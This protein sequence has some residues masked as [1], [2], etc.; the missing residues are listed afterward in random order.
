MFT[1]SS[2]CVWKVSAPTESPWPF[3]RILMP[4]C[5]SPISETE[6]CDMKLVYLKKGTS[7]SHLDMCFQTPLFKTT[8]YSLYRAMFATAHHTL[9][10]TVTAHSRSLSIS[11]SLLHSLSRRLLHSFEHSSFFT[12]IWTLIFLY[13]HFLT[14][15][16]SPPSVFSLNRSATQ[17][18]SLSL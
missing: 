12:L 15:F 11:D 8:Y 10:L 14:H 4:V 3:Q 5:A 17:P 6:V 18:L 2:E 1:R 13:T 7:S 16:H 9:S